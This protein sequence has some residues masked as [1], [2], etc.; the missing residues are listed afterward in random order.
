M[1]NYNRSIYILIGSSYTFLYK[2]IF[3]YSTQIF[4]LATLNWLLLGHCT[5][6]LR[7]VKCCLLNRMC[8][9]LDMGILVL[10]ISDK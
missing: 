8:L 9:K 1:Y 5:P 2:N 3:K 7:R 4:S 6:G 10:E